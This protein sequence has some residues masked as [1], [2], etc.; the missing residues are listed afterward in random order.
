M[1]FENDI[2][3]TEV[4]EVPPAASVFQ[5]TDPKYN[6]SYR[7]ASAVVSFL[8][9]V[10]PGVI[11]VQ[12]WGAKMRGQGV[13]ILAVKPSL[14]VEGTNPN[15]TV[16]E[17]LFGNQPVNYVARVDFRG[18]V[19]DKGVDL[20]VIMDRIA[21]QRRET[22]IQSVLGVCLDMAGMAS[23]VNGVVKDGRPL[24][25][26]AEA[27]QALHGVDDAVSSICRNFQ[28]LLI[29]EKRV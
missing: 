29:A 28:N 23:A 2:D 13:Y 7:Q 17:I 11:S 14:P 22:A 27:Y 25:T 3:I 12:S 4:P 5:E 16:A 15:E 6:L 19:I 26:P 10:M 1:F 21:N 20:G 8:N 24:M 9:L 18:S